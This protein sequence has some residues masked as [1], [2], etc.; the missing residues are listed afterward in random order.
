MVYGGGMA[1]Q[2]ECL[3]LAKQ[4]KASARGP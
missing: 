3:P 2:C 4:D 1:R